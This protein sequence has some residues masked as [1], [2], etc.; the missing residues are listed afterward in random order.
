[1]AWRGLPEIEAETHAP[2]RR[3]APAF[4]PLAFPDDA[5]A[6]LCVLASGSRGNCSVLA[7][8]GAGDDS[9]AHVMLIDAGLSPARTRSLL[10]RRGV[11]LHRVRD[12][13]LTHLD[14]DHFHPGWRRSASTKATMRLHRAHLA[15]AEREMSLLRRNEPFADG[16][17]SG[18][19]RARSIVCDHDSAG[20]AIYRFA[21]DTPRGATELGYATDLGRPTPRLVQHLAG[22]PVLAIESN[23]CP[24]MQAASDRPAFLKRR[25]TGGAGHLSN[26]EAAAAIQ[27]IGP[28]ERVVFLHLSRECNSP[29]AVGELHAGADY[30]WVIADQHQP[31]PWIWLRAERAGES[32]RAGRAARGADPT[33]LLWSHGCEQKAGGRA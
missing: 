11:P 2:P 5:V 14:R 33:P 22:V 23:Y 10:S 16:F 32:T 20:V 8:R 1:M 12:V 3:P 15:R 4:E 24:S 29:D 17:E 31:T 6:G 25:I 28:R 9:P 19:V 26:H 30:H 7:V 21:I 13:V 27:D 18:P